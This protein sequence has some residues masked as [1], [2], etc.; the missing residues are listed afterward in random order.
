MERN[1]IDEI[2]AGSTERNRSVSTAAHSDR[3]SGAALKRPQVTD[4]LTRTFFEEWARVGYGAMSL[5]TVARKAGVGKAALYRRWRSKADMASDL[6]AQVAAT[7]PAQLAEKD[8]GSLEADLYAM[9]LVG[10]RMMQNPLVR[11]IMPDLYAALDRE[12]VLAAALRPSEAQRGAKVRQVIERAVVRGELAPHLDRRLAFNLL[13]GPL[14][15]QLVILGHR[16][17]RSQLK[18]LARALTAALTAA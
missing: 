8:R 5:E 4:A 6:V 18:A 13:F 2:D 11:R 16:T 17:D 15:W 3:L 7:A 14:Y 10:A 1:R 12:P 9:L